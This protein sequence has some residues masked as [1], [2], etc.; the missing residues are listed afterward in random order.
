MK[1]LVIYDSSGRIYLMQYGATETPQGIL[2]MWVDIPEGAI[3]ERIDVT[4]DNNH[5]PVYTYLPESDIGKLQNQVRQISDELISTQLALAEQYEQNL[6]LQEEVTATQL[7]L[8][9]IYE[10][11]V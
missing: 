1:T 11:M 7:A 2:Y 3:L 8:T 10:G 6:A 5:K 9:E 4:D